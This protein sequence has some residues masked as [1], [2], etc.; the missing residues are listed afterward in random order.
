MQCLGSSQP[1]DEKHDKPADIKLGR[2]RSVVSPGKVS[3][4]TTISISFYFI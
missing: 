4:R 2:S 3:V 1:S